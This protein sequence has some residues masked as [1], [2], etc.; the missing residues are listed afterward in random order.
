MLLYELLTGTTPFDG[1]LRKVAF[2]EMRRIIRGGRASRPSNA[3]AR[4]RACLPPFENRR[5]EPQELSRLFR[6]EL[7]W[8]VMKA[9]EKERDRAL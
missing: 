4:L 6:N 5:S 3:S 9:L 8:I 2:D 7:D 1:E